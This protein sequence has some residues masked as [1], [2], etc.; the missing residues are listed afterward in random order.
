[1]TTRPDTEQP[2]FFGPGKQLFGFYH[3]APTAARKAVLLCPPLGQDQIRC[4]RLYRQLAH[5]LVAE[6]IAVLRF[7]YYGTGDSAGGSA[8]VDWD[9]CIA[10]TVAAADEL[11]ARSGTDRVVAFGARLGG[12]VALAAVSA[13]RLA[14]IVAWD[15]VLDGNAYVARLDAMQAELLVDPKRFLQPRLRADIDDQWLGFAI[16][17][18]LRRQL[19]ELRPGPAST[20]VLV[21]DSLA[22]AS[23]RSWQDLVVDQAMVK[24]LQPP[25]PWDEMSRLEIAILSHPLIQMVTGYM[26]EA[27]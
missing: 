11:R 7:D 5:A 19:M 14:G 17:D 23:A 20:P 24:T 1:M 27:A 15:P 3:P 2:F 4:H 16:S 26:R 22:P 25:T 21:L 8:E 12:S 13:A 6:G 18:R 9:R 10:D